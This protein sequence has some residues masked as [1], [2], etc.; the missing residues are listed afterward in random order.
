MHRLPLNNPSITTIS[1]LVR[2]A[3][4]ALLLLALLVAITPAAQAKKKF[5]ETTDDGL[6]LVKHTKLRAV[7]MKP[8]VSLASYDRVAILD[9]YVA[10]KKGFLREY[11]EGVVLQEDRLTQEDM[12]RMKQE[13]ADEFKKVFTKELTKKGYPV[14]AEGGEG[15]LVLR[16][17]IIDL[18]VTAPDIMTPM[19][20]TTIVA[21]SGEMTLYLELYDGVSDTLIGRIIDPEESDGMGGMAANSVTNK[22]A[23]DRILRRWADSLRSHLGAVQPLKQE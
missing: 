5:P 21:S 18:V 14:V 9:C 4:Y 11:N 23:A 6:T 3:G 19:M 8:G 17:A 7:Y 22:A 2:S 20:E 13:L 12:D 1:S 16:P 15:V 10:F